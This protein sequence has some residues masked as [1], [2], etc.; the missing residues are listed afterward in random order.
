MPVRS[1]SS[2]VFRWP[3]L[4]T[5]RAAAVEWAQTAAAARADVLRIGMW[6]SCARGDWGVGSDLDLVVVLASSELS[7]ERR[8]V[9]WDTTGLPVPTDLLVY[10]EAEWRRLDPQS[11]FART[12]GDETRWLFAR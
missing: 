4:E 9:E 1:T 5:V 3:D 12:L 8:S 2:S 7:W 11:R 6:G 10:T